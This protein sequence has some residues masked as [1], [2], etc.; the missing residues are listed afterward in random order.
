MSARR[1]RAGSGWRTAV[2]RHGSGVGCDSGHDWTDADPPGRSRCAGAVTKS[3]VSSPAR[4]RP[5]SSI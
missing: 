2:A 5:W 3:A 4:T 1:F